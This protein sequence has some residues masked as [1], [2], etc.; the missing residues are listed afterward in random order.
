MIRSHRSVNVSRF[1]S[2]VRI[3]RKSTV[4]PPLDLR[5]ENSPHPPNLL[6]LL[7]TKTIFPRGPRVKERNALEF[8]VETVQSLATPASDMYTLISRMP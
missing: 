3:P 5:R 1:F 4:E 6:Q 8:S 2:L 7:I